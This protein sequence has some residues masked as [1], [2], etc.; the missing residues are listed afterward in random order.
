MSTILVRRDTSFR[1]LNALRRHDKLTARQ[2]SEMTGLPESLVHGNLKTY[3]RQGIL[4]V[5]YKGCM[6]RNTRRKQYAWCAGEAEVKMAFTDIIK[7]EKPG[8]CACGQ[9]AYRIKWGSPVCKDCDAIESD[10]WGHRITKFIQR[11][12]PFRDDDSLQKY[13]DPCR[14]YSV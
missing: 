5:E 3:V 14:V 8:R 1:L 10:M 7:P 13:A 9:L 12:R 6:S 4:G 2:L 11:Y